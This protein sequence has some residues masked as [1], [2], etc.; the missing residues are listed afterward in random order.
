MFMMFSY[1]AQHKHFQCAMTQVFFCGRNTMKSLF[2]IVFWQK[3]TLWAVLATPQS[4]NRTLLRQK[5]VAFGRR[6]VLPRRKEA[7]VFRERSNLEMLILQV[8]VH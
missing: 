5:V 6:L 8:R 1:A 2:L 3:T 4:K 7:T